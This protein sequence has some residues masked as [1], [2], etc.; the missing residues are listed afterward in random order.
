MSETHVIVEELNATEWDS[1]VAS[2]G[3][4]G[5]MQ[6]SAWAKVK[7]D[8]GWEIFQIAIRRKN[9]L[10][11]A[12]LILGSRMENK[13]MFFYSPQGPVLKWH[14]KSHVQ[15]L[16]TLTDAVAALSNR[17]NG[18]CWRME[19]WLL[20]SYGESLTQFQPSP[21]NMQ[22][23]D[24][25]LV[26]LNSSYEDVIQ[27]FHPK[28]RYNIRIAL[29]DGVTTHTGCE[30]EDFVEFYEN[31]KK[32]I[33]RKSL[34]FKEWE[35]FI[36]IQKHLGS[37]KKAFVITA[38]LE[39]MAIASIL[40]ICF[41]D[42]VTYFFGGFDYDARKHMAPYLCHA[43][44]IKLGIEHKCAF[45]DLWGIANSDNKEHPWQSFTDFKLKF[46]PVRVTLAGAYDVVYDP[47]GY[48]PLI[49]I[50]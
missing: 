15:D 9:K 33:D 38:K 21:L 49:G 36:S 41:A 30:L 34:E 7:K 45:Y 1:F 4:S 3:Y 40:V 17:E 26:P 20:H 50:N 8:E 47:E 32:T 28:V 44:A 23:V 5:F 43:E 24:T 46:N 11:A 31:Y 22:P 48:L 6:T 13:K 27:K 14:L 10:V 25:G 12:A 35:Y 18:I 37:T 16:R 2:T 29:R 39:D 19:P 42:R